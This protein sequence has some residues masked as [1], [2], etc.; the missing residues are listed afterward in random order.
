MY[1]SE[2]VHTHLRTCTCVFECVCGVCVCTCEHV[3]STVSEIAGL[4]LQFATQNCLGC[5]SKLNLGSKFLAKV[6]THPSHM[7]LRTLYTSNI[8]I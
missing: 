4:A 8:K 5:Y 2:G 1:E 7:I 3:C 6:A